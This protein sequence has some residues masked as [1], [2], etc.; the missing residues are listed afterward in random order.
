VATCDRG[1]VEIA[2]QPANLIFGNGFEG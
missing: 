1:A 2:A